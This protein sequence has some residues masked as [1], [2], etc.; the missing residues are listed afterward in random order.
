M[1]GNFPEGIYVILDG[2]SIKPLF[3]ELVHTVHT[4]AVIALDY[5]KRSVTYCFERTAKLFSY[6]FCL[7]YSEELL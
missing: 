1:T 4:I 5:F 6:F 7:I 3:S 2:L